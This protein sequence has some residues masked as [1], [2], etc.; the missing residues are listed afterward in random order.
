M[1]DAARSDQSLSPR[2]HSFQGFCPDA[3]V[4]LQAGKWDEFECLWKLVCELR[5]VGWRV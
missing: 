2:R 1:N 5:D 3:Q 4:A